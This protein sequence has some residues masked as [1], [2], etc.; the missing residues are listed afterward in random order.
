MKE[1]I[2]NGALIGMSAALLWHFLYI[3]RYEQYLVGE[4]NIIIRS[5][6]TAGLL[7]ILV[8]GISKYIID[9]KREVGKR[10]THGDQ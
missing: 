8:F 6:E 9:L 7:I 5:L 3:W 2:A 1:V 4:P 10:N